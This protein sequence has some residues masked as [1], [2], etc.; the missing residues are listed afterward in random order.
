MIR[1]N[2]FSLLLLFLYFVLF[3]FLHGLFV[4]SF[5]FRDGLKLQGW[6]FYQLPLVS[7]IFPLDSVKCHLAYYEGDE[8]SENWEDTISV[9]LAE[10]CLQWSTPVSS[11]ENCSVTHNSWW[12]RSYQANGFLFYKSRIYAKWMTWKKVRVLEGLCLFVMRLIYNSRLGMY[13]LN[14]LLFTKPSAEHVTAA[15]CVDP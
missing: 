13:F 4:R 14:L 9:V 7:F 11:N 2:L 12:I 10:A 6:N 8:I 3:C 5:V 15:I 1:L